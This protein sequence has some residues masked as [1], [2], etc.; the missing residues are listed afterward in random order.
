MVD[1]LTDVLDTVRVQS[2]CYGR[3]EL[4]APWGVAVPQSSDAAFHVVARGRAWLESDAL[5]PPAVLEQGD[6]V[7][8]P[9]GAAHVIKDAPDTEP[10]PLET[11]LAGKRS[12]DERAFRA[13]GDGEVSELV[14]GVFRFEERT[15][16]LLVGALPPVIVLRADKN[17][18]VPWLETTLGFIASEI[19]SGRPGAPIVVSRLA[20]VLFI[21]ILRGYLA[22]LSSEPPGWLR[23]LSEPQIGV[24]LSLV[25]QNP[26]HDWTVGSLASRVGMSRSAFAERF[27]R[28]LGM[29]PL[30]YVTRWRMQ[31]AAGMLRDG[32]ATL[33]EVAGRVGY[34]SEAAFSKAF[35]RSLGTTPG[36]YRR[37][38]RSPEER[39]GPPREE[40]SSPAAMGS[41]EV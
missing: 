29:P 25:H 3:L 6:L 21:Q 20:D 33:A 23:A 30:E 5:E 34:D 37:S 31:K 41:A 2:V 38:G 14:C 9:R 1:V 16:N 15:S 11:V 10:Q 36:A 7:M 40:R 17:R 8:L 26:E 28:T 39:G 4:G 13:G 18:S 22:Q 32:S 24:A 27:A 12:D 35:K 19:K